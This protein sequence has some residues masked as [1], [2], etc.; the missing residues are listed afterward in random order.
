[1]AFKMRSSPMQRNYGI[2]SSPHKGIWDILGKGVKKVKDTAS[3]INKKM[4]SSYI[5]EQKS[6]WG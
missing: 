6:K 2:G 1:M 4:R 5:E 3:K